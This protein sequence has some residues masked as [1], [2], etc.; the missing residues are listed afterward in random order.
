MKKILIIIGVIVIVSVAVIFVMKNFSIDSECKSKGSQSEINACYNTK[1][2]F[3][4]IISLR[5]NM[6]GG[7]QIKIGER[8]GMKQ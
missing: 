1:A 7:Y 3:N 5:V 8:S 2:F 6:P 4:N